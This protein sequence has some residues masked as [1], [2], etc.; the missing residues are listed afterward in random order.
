M[1]PTAIVYVSNTGHT[2]R[3]AELLSVRTHL[4]AYTLDEARKALPKGTPV[5]FMG[6]LFASSV[7]GYKKA[8]KLY[9]IRIVCAVGLCDTG[10]LTKE[11]RKAISL[12]EGIPLFTVQGGMDRSAL[13]GVNKFMINML[14]KMM[15][16]KK[17]RTRD[18]ERMLT[19][20]K[21]G[22]DFVDAKNLQD[23]LS[24]YESGE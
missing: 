17:D 5:I 3:Y 16:N 23:I 1:G 14:D 18:E 21:K 15:S 22:G 9:D 10:A 4:P 6:W 20:I 24:L 8:A 7:K 19:L 11:A 2:A 12:P 13:T